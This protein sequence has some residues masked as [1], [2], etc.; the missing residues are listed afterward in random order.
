MKNYLE[1]L[2]LA[3]LA[4]FYPIKTVLMA[5]LALIFADLFFGLAAA[6]K[7]GE[8]ITSKGLKRSVVKIMVYE[9]AIASGYLVH[10]YLTGDL[11]PADKLIASLIG[12]TELKS[13]LESLQEIYGEPFFSVVIKKIVSDETQ[14]L[15]KKD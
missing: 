4:V 14:G 15:E 11:I 9:L 5:V 12:I 2:L 10:T 1:S 13:V 3:A 7:R 6:K 8:A